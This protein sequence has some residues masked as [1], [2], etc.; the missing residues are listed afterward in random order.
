MA[1][2]NFG[3]VEL[4]V[5]EAKPWPF[6][7]TYDDGGAPRD[8]NADVVTF[9]AYKDDGTTLF[10][11]ITATN[12]TAT[13]AAAKAGFTGSQ[14]DVKNVSFSTTHTASG[15]KGRYYAELI[16]TAGAVVEKSV[17]DLVIA[18]QST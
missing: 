2:L 6:A 14:T 5:G 10:A 4:L 1:L 18:G 16:R 11:A 9:I 3:K 7:F 8:V 13:D 17:G 12:G 15:N